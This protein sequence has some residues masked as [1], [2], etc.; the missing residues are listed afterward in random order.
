MSV[1][2]CVWVCEREKGSKDIDKKKSQVPQQIKDVEEMLHN[3]GCHHKQ[4]NA[5]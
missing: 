2:V 3:V 4:H 1:N 5:L